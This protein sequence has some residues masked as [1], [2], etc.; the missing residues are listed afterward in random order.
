[1]ATPGES[2][3]PSKVPG[4]SPCT[5]RSG[6]KILPRESTSNGQIVSAF[7][8][9]FFKFKKQKRYFKGIAHK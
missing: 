9:F 5:R 7:A 6:F 3:D 1:M 4:S 8:L 2:G